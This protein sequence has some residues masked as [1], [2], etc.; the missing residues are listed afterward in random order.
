MQESPPWAG[1]IFHRKGC[2]MP[3]H[4]FSLEYND[5]FANCVGGRATAKTAHDEV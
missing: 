2:H 5:F 4:M 1:Y 3:C